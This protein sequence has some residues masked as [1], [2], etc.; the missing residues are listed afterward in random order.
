L[1]PAHGNPGL[2]V[3][4]YGRSA[5]EAAPGTRRFTPRQSLEASRAIA[6]LHGLADARTAFAAQSPKAID[7]GVFHNDVIAVGNEGVFFCHEAAFRDRHVLLRELKR[8]Y[9]ALGGGPLRV[10]EVGAR[11]VPL[12]A[13]VSTYLF[14]SQLLSLPE[15]GMLLLAAG[16]CEADA[17]TRKYLSALP[18]RGGI[19]RV[20]FADL[21]QSMRNGGGPACLRL[22]VVL[23]DAE[24][25]AVPAGVKFTEDAYA[26]LKPWIEMRYRDRLLPA[27]LADPGLAEECR[28]TT[29]G[30]YEILGLP[31]SL[32]E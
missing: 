32:A 31:K 25:D 7:A 11:E 21:R 14:N 29:R 9:A 2:Q 20:E 30:I 6:R 28:I 13:A 10:I 12:S 18:S 19:T 24:W 3:F 5:S 22:R 4:A 15:G 27:D 26:R 16:E 23:T 17:R 1:A 8:K